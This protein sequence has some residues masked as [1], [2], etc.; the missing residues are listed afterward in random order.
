VGRFVKDGP[1]PDE[2]APIESAAPADACCGPLHTGGTLAAVLGV[3][4]SLVRHWLRRGLLSATRRAGSLAWFDFDQFVV[5]R[6]LAGLL[7]RGLSPRDI[8]RCLAELG[9]GSAALGARLPGRLVHERGGLA[10]YVDGH[11]LGPS[12]QRHLPFLDEAV[13]RESPGH[14]EV[15]VLRVPAGG[16]T[17]EA[18]TCPDGSMAAATLAAC[19]PGSARVGRS[20]DE[21]AEASDPLDFEPRDFLD[22]AGDL[23]AD[24]DLEAACEAIRALL[25]SR[26]PTAEA[27]FML[28]EMLYRAGDLTAARER[29]YAAI[30]LDPD[31]LMARMSLGCLLAELGERD[32]AIAALEGVVEQRPDFADAHW[33]LATVLEQAGN[34]PR[35]R[36]HLEEFVAVAPESPWATAARERL[37]RC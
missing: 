24:G 23:A 13:A 20:A 31:H 11:L 29:F 34:L 18:A 19:A 1:A 17:P 16:E 21:A 4:E 27:V 26:P 14:P 22:L 37:A 15:D 8:E 33:H 30:E 2:P 28:A 3:P 36:F 10:I 9:S 7:A 6:R 5:G 35:S 12:G 32:L 25:Q